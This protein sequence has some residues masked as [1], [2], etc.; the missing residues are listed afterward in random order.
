MKLEQQVCSL[1]LAKKLKE[2]GVKQESL[3]VWE[4]YITDGPGKQHGSWEVRV[5]ID[6]PWHVRFYEPVPTQLV[7]HRISA[8]TVAEIGHMIWLHA[9]PSEILLAYG[10]IFNVPDTRTITPEGLSQCMEDPDIGAKMLIYLIEHKLLTP[11]EG[12]TNTQDT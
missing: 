6:H 7:S 9:S 3:W 4:P 5:L 8:F 2:L 10:H 11:P 12:E 1:E